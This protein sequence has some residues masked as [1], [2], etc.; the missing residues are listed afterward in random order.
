MVNT[1]EFVEQIEEVMKKG[2]GKEIR[3][4]FLPGT[5]LLF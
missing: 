4:F 5:F 2:S 3:L 1:R